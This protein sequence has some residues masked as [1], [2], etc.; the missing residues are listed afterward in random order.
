MKGTFNQ[1][2]WNCFESFASELLDDNP[3][4]G[5]I[6]FNVLRDAGITKKEVA[7]HLEHSTF[8][9]AKV[10]NVIRQYWYSLINKKV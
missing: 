4:A 7:Y 6:C 8:Y 3:Y 2:W 1:G 5:S 10:E 9:D